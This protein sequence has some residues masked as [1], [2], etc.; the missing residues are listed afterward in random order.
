LIYFKS[1]LE[2]S[3]WGSTGDP[4]V[5]SGDSPDGTAATFRANEYGLLAMMTPAVP[6]GGSPTE[7]GESPTL[8]MSIALPGLDGTM[9]SGDG[10]RGRLDR[11]RRRLADGP[12][13]ALHGLSLRQFVLFCQNTGQVGE[14]RGHV[15]M[16]RP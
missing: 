7:A 16:L 6:V 9:Q 1:V 11:S 15:R 13:A 4:P 10:E 5:P 8:P 2:K 14:C 12:A 3:F